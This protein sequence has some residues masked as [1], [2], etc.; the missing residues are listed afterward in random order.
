MITIKKGNHRSNLRFP[1]LTF[2]KSIKV[3]VKFI[4]DFSYSIKKQ[5]DANKLFGLSDSYHHHK[6]SVRVGWRWNNIVKKVELMV[7][8][9]S[10]GNRTIKHLRYLPINKRITIELEVKEG[11]YI[12]K[13]NNDE[14]SF[15][16]TSKWWFLRYGLFPFFGR[17][18]VAP[19]DFQ[20]TIKKIT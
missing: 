11:E 15:E 9:Y 19:K 18:T 1:L 5:K 12:I 14:Y 20:F 16:R 2:K 6:D 17:T 7:I 10:G 4:G 8:V 13:L 3:E